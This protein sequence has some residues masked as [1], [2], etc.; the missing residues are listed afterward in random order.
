MPVN[1][2]SASEA[3][4]HP[5]RRQRESGRPAGDYPPTRPALYLCVFSE[6]ERVFDVHPEL[7]YRALDVRMAEEQLHRTQVAGGVVGHAPDVHWLHDRP[8]QGLAPLP[9]PS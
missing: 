3:R 9:C 6:S 5:V 7:A 4:T 2:M 1:A 8:L